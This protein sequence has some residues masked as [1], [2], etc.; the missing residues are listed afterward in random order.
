[1][2]FLYYSTIFN[3]LFVRLILIVDKEV[4]EG[5]DVEYIKDVNYAP[6]YFEE[7]LECAISNRGFDPI[8]IRNE[9]EMKKVKYRK[10][11]MKTLVSESFE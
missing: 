7:A 10:M 9:K 3:P 1:M 11:N 5:K 2:D 4:R 6:L 8:V